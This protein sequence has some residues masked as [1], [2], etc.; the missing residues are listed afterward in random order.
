MNINAIADG[1]SITVTWSGTEEPVS[2]S[3]TED[4]GENWTLV[5]S[6][7]DSGVFVDSG[8]EPGVTYRYRAR[9]LDGVSAETADVWVLAQWGWNTV[10]QVWT[11]ND[12]VNRP[13]CRARILTAADRKILQPD[14]V[15]GV[16][17]TVYAVLDNDVTA[18]PRWIPITDTADLDPD[19]CLSP[20]LIADDVWRDN[21]GYNFSHTPDID[22]EPGDYVFRYTLDTAAGPVF[23]HFR[24]KSQCRRA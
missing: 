5:S 22:L 19:A 11:A 7:D 3:R 6:A 20:N 13:T 24:Y 23:V 12:C 15:R 4:G 2:L 1:S 10:T 14:A 9:T 21:D 17:L 16:T 8:P 18:Q